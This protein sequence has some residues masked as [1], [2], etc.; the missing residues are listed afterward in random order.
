MTQ[1]SPNVRNSLGVSPDAALAV[2]TRLRE[3]RLQQ[4]RT[5]PR[6]SASIKV[7]EHYLAAI[8]EGD[9]DRL[10]HGL[11]GRGLVRLYAR[12]LGVQVPELDPKGQYPLANTPALAPGQDSLAAP[13]QESEWK[14]SEI[15]RSIPRS[16]APARVPPAHPTSAPHVHPPIPRRPQWPLEPLE[17]RGNLASEEEPIDVTTPDVARVLGLDRTYLEDPEQTEAPAAKVHFVAPPTAPMPVPAPPPG[18]DD[19]QQV[20]PSRQLETPPGATSSR[21]I[22][23]DFEPPSLALSQAGVPKGGSRDW[24]FRGLLGLAAACI[25]A[26]GL[27]VILTRNDSPPQGAFFEKI[28]GGASDSFPLSATQPAAQ[29]ENASPEAAAASG[30]APSLP[31]SAPVAVAAAPLA[32]ATLAQVPVVAPN[33]A[34]LAPV[35]QAPRLD[36]AALG[37]LTVV[38]PVTLRVLVDGKVVLSG[39][40]NPGPLPLD[41]KSSADIL[42]DDGSKVSLTYKGWDHGPL[43]V[44]GRKRRIILRAV[45]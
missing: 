15:I 10:P 12:E 2:G 41:Y 30:A 7:R 35:P 9:W 37:V 3:T 24:F 27:A 22:V 23:S 44:A 40:Q 28:E 8:E 16:A 20:E 11:N 39:L 38:S 21:L 5:L 43:G 32:A 17:T 19:A 4:Q 29:G 6:V 31:A 1:P 13:V 14:R 36:G 34:A 25:G 45:D 33:P 42:V 26:V 18:V